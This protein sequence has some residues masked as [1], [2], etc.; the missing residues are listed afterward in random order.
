[1]NNNFI[2]KI[3]ISEIF[4]SE[5]P[6]EMERLI[7]KYSG[8]I[9]PPLI[10]VG[11]NEGLLGIEGESFL[12]IYI[13]GFFIK[14]GIPV[15]IIPLNDSLIQKIELS[16]K[17]I[18][19]QLKNCDN[20]SPI[21]EKEKGTGCE[22]CKQCLVRNI[23]EVPKYKVSAYMCYT[24]MLI[25]SVPIYVSDRIVA[26]LTTEH[27]KPKENSLWKGDLI[28]LDLC[29]LPMQVI[30]SGDIENNL[31]SPIPNNLDLWQESK[32]RI[33][34]CEELL[35]LE[36][37]Q[38]LNLIINK[39]KQD[40]SFEIL[41]EDFENILIPQLEKASKHISD[42]ANKTYK[43][44]KESVIG[45]IRA[46]MG[47]ALS[48]IDTFWQKISWCLGNFLR[49]LGLD[50][51]LLLSYDKTEKYPLNLLC[52]YGLNE[53]DIDVFSSWMDV[54]TNQLE[55]FIDRIKDNKDIQEI[56]LRKYR[57]LPILNIIYS[58][59]GR[60]LNYPV[61][62]AQTTTLDNRITFLLLGKTNPF[63]YQKKDSH[64]KVSIADLVK[65]DDRHFLMSIIH[66]LA[67]ITRVFSSIKKIQDTKEERTNIMESVAHD[68]KTPI[69]N[70][71]VAADN[72]R[73]GRTSPQQAFKTIAGVVTQLERL[74]LLAEKAWML[75]Q[76]KQNSL[77]Y[78]DDKK[79]NIYKILVE[80]RDIM[81]DLAESKS[82][83]IEIDPSIRTW[84]EVQLDPDKFRLV[85]MNLIQNG[86]KYS[87]SDTTIRIG[88]WV[89][90]TGSGISITFAN[91]GIPIRDEEKDRIFE[92]YYRSKE[93][94]IKDPSGSG[95][96]LVLVKEFVDHYNGRIEVDSKEVGFGRFLN[97]FSLYFQGR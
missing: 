21:Y 58:L 65:N 48:S 31:Y 26:I 11:E 40:T 8:G 96:G 87:F 95:I 53:E 86:I 61:L 32:K 19:D 81:S 72:L 10:A 80:C 52:H 82:I 49:L 17:N 28:D 64:G 4:S 75:E 85:V 38:I 56:D 24:G 74:N 83:R 30:T 68:L 43:L 97:V 12:D 36:N 15:Y 44:E 34:E 3:N 16:Y 2:S 35:G 33:K 45:W 42:I 23:S 37:D 91:E 59:Y 41:P 47:S 22:S 88:G 39:T 9:I 77:I 1:M 57:Y 6:P 25:L 50:Y 78:N 54:S 29:K 92:R 67:I 76:I 13:K 84:R 93:A 60:G 7:Q 51:G 63:L 62:I 27:R 55:E 79:I 18:I 73:S 14:Y 94:I 69:T 90:V 66:D 20:I 5:N 89:D 71:M 70:I 46:E